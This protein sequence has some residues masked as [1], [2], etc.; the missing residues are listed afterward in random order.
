MSVCMHHLSK[1]EPEAHAEIER[2]LAKLNTLEAAVRAVRDA[3]DLGFAENM[4]DSLSKR[5][6]LYALVEELKP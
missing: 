6:A 5:K 2:L 1:H 3:R 4:L